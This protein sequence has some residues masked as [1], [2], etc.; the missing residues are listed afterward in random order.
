MRFYERLGF[1][2][3]AEVELP[4]DGPRTWCMRREPRT[5]A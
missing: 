1:T 5:Q 3:T 2:V 4:D